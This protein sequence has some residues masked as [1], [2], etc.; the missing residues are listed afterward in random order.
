M[1]QKKVC[2]VCAHV[3]KK[4]TKNLAHKIVKNLYERTN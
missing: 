4:K 3:F 1:I 2:D